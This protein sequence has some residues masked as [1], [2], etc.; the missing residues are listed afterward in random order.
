MKVYGLTNCDTCRK[1]MKLL[2]ESEL[3]DLRAT[4]MSIEV[5]NQAYKQFEGELVNKRSTTWRNLPDSDRNR[6]PLEL[7]SEYPALMKRPLIERD[8]E[9]FLGWTDETRAALG[10]G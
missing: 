4:P 10:I 9:L 7:L 6:D 8:G 2:P 3:L 5:L 1:V